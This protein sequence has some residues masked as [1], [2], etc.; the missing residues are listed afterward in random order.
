MDENITTMKELIDFAK[1]EKL[2]EHAAYVYAKSKLNL[3]LHSEVIGGPSPSFD[4]NDD[5][6]LPLLVRKLGYVALC[7]SN[8]LQDVTI[9]SL[10]RNKNISDEEIVS[11][12]MFYLENDD[13][14]S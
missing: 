6:V 10:S 5:K 8:I 13:F 7:D 9:S 2:S 4:D 14:R 11:D 12:L 3:M 1:A